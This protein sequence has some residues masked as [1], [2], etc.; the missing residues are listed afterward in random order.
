MRI[1]DKVRGETANMNQAA[2][3][4]PKVH[5]HSEIRNSNYH[6][7]KHRSA[8]ERIQLRH[9]ALQGNRELKVATISE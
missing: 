4:R 7:L 6:R 1:L 8:G 5:K 9:F 2:T 3:F